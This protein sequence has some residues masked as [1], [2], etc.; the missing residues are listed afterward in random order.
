MQSSRNWK[1][2][3]NA[4]AWSRVNVW[5]WPACVMPTSPSR[6]ETVLEKHGEEA[7]NEDNPRHHEASAGGLKERP[8]R[9][10]RWPRSGQSLELAALR[11]RADAT[12]DHCLSQS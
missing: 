4:K 11:R 2:I 7:R 6:L 1:T 10:R 3:S 5:R 8:Q 9:G 12:I